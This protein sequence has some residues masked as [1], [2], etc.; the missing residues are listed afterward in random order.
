MHERDNQHMLLMEC[1]HIITTTLYRI[2]DDLHKR[3]APS[4]QHGEMREATDRRLRQDRRPCFPS[5]R[6]AS[7]SGSLRAHMSDLCGHSAGSPDGK[8]ISR[9]LVV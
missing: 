6:L 2:L 3:E 1:T 9:A 8:G 7:A 5:V 4:C